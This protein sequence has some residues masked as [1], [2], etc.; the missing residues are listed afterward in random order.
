MQEIKNMIFILLNFGS[1]LKYAISPRR[2]KSSEVEFSMKAV[3]KHREFFYFRLINIKYVKHQVIYNLLK[4]NSGIS[5]Q[6][7][8]LHCFLIAS[9]SR[10]R[11]RISRSFVSKNHKYQSYHQTFSFFQTDRHARKS[12]NP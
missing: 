3:S 4:I 5:S 10:E 12:R 9:E 11:C 6:L 8:M 1:R 2:L 7:L